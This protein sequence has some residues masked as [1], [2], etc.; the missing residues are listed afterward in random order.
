MVKRRNDPGRR[1][2]DHQWNDVLFA[3]ESQEVPAQVLRESLEAGVR[4][5]CALFQI[6]RRSRVIGRGIY[7][8]QNQE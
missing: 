2:A 7:R 5:R 3:E 8:R 1:T 6:R 4:R